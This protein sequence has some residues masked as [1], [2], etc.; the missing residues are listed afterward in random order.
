V[1]RARRGG[2]TLGELVALRRSIEAIPATQGGARGVRRPC[3]RSLAAEIT[4]ARPGR[5][6]S[7]RAGGD[8]RLSRAP[9]E[10]CGGYD[11][12]LDA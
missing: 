2:Q 12:E 1:S 5:P 7:R 10:R 4:V 9:A 8:P 11:E 3:G 6:S